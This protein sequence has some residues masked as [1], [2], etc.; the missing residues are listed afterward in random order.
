MKVFFFPQ[1]YLSI[2]C[3]QFSL[4]HVISVVVGVGWVWRFF[5]MLGLHCDA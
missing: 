4:L 5:V 2:G 3:H 1:M